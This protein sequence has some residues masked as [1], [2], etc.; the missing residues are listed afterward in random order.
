MFT[1]FQPFSIYE[2]QIVEI[3]AS[4]SQQ[5]QLLASQKEIEQ[6]YL[7]H[8]LKALTL[9]EEIF[10]KA[11]KVN[12]GFVKNLIKT[13]PEIIN[14][15]ENL[16]YFK[17]RSVNEILQAAKALLDQLRPHYQIVTSEAHLLAESIA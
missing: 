10:Y 8:R 13:N 3:Q 5:T 14:L 17:G 9:Y 11:E 1:D 12:P 6:S 15:S 2:K 16:R 7:D 4:Y